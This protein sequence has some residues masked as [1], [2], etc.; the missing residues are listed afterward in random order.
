MRTQGSRDSVISTRVGNVRVR[1]HFD[2]YAQIG[3][4][5]LELLFPRKTIAESVQL[6]VHYEANAAL[7]FL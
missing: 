6:A 4:V 3:S 2:F 7:E 1:L 5:K